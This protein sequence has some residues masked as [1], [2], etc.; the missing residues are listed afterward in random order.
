MHISLE[1]SYSPEKVSLE[2]ASSDSAVAVARAAPPFEY[3]ELPPPK[4]TRRPG[5]DSERSGNVE[6]DCGV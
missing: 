1:K 4:R 3:V 5:I 6:Q 2:T